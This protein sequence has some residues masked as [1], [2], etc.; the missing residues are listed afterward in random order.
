MLSTRMNGKGVRCISALVAAGLIT[1]AAADDAHAQQLR[2]ETT[3]PGGIATAGNTLGLAKD[4]GLNGPG[5]AHS[6]G[7][8]ITT[9]M[10]SYD[11]YPANSLNP[12]FAGTT[13]DWT[14]NGS[15]AT[16]SAKQSSLAPLPWP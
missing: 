13:P 15:S 14:Q 16:L 10:S 7:T 8:F 3:A 6:I 2:F 9:N 11:D 1:F 12:W 5:V 4:Y